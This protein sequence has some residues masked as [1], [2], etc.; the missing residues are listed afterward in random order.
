[1]HPATSHSHCC[2]PLLL[3]LALPWGLSTQQQKLQGM[4]SWEA[5]TVNSEALASSYFSSHPLQQA[6]CSCSCFLNSITAT[7]SAS[8]H[9]DSSSVWKRLDSVRNRWQQFL[10]CCM[11][12]RSRRNG[13]R[14]S[15]GGVRSGH[16]ECTALSYT[17][18]RF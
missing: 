15:L 7:T 18:H 10:A 2:Q 13:W 9:K 5:R 6:G 4:H 14:G 17:Y 12:T 8:I 16:P 1:M 3:L 11:R